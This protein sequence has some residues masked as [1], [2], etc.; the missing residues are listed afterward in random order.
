MSE[1]NYILILSMI[2]LPYV[3]AIAYF[4]VKDSE[5]LEGDLTRIGALQEAEFGWNQPQNHQFPNI[6]Q[7]RG[8]RFDLRRCR[9][10]RFFF[11]PAA[12]VVD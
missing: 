10:W 1:R 11:F 3:L 6:P 5:P 7:R 9:T 4:T 2:C 12:H 8:L